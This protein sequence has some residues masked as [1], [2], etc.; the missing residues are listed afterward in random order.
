MYIERDKIRDLIYEVPNVFTPEE[1]NEIINLEGEWK[2]GT[3]KADHTV[4]F[5]KDEIKR[6]SKVKFVNSEKILKKLSPY[7]DEAM[8]AKQWKW[9]LTGVDQFQITEYK[10]GEYYGW[11][12]DKFESP[13]ED[14]TNR[15][16]SCIIQL[17]DPKIYEGGDVEIEANKLSKE[18]GTISFFPAFAAHQVQ[19][20]TKGKRYSLIAWYRGPDMEGLPYDR[21]A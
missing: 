19:P 3:V 15:L 2:D 4:I 18:Q 12:S 10:E 5:E 6:K 16:M 1:C 9:E 17:S 11:H 8:L 20:V 7:V 14:G 13:R 21:L